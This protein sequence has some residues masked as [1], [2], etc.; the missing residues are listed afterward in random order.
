MKKK[1][2]YDNHDRWLKN[3]KYLLLILGNQYNLLNLKLYIKH[4]GK[5]RSKLTS[6][7]EFVMN[8]K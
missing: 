4:R 6:K 3:R 2:V 5:K 8:I 7:P 1:L